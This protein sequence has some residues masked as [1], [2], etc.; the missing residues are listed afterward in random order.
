[1]RTRLLTAKGN[2]DVTD[3]RTP[4][5]R[6]NVRI[7]A[8]VVLVLLLLPVGAYASP[9][10]DG[11]AAYNHHDP[12]T[13]L[14][15]LLPLAEQG[16][17]DAQLFVAKLY[18]VGDT[19]LDPD[20]AKSAKWYIAAADSYR[21]AADQGN[22]EAQTELGYLYRI[23]K[24]VPLDQ[25][26]ALKWTRKAADQGYGKAQFLL[27]V[28][29]TRGIG[30]W[31]AAHEEA[32]FWLSLAAKSGIKDAIEWRDSNAARLTSKQIEAEKKRVEEWKPVP[33][34]REKP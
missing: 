2:V 12:Q 4:F 29:Y 8:V 19:G 31:F 6:S 22:A 9:L 13:A 21:K 1:M 23:G 25:T 14:K 20:K 18:E 11:I 7:A 28:M 10:D 15:T 17:A 33:A 32:Y 16:N 27:G 34:V 26:E 30:M 3:Q 5:D 24:G